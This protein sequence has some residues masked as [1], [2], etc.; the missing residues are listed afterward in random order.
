M[1]QQDQC[2]TSLPATMGEK[3]PQAFN[4]KYLGFREAKGLW[5]IKHTR[6]P[7]E[8]MVASVKQLKSVLN[9]MKLDIREDGC[10]LESIFKANIES[11]FFSIDSIS[12]GV[13]DVVYSRVFSMITVKQVTDFPSQ[14][15]FQCHAFICESKLTARKLTRALAVAF[16]HYSVVKVKCVPTTISSSLTASRLATIANG[17]RRFAVD[18]RTPEELQNDLKSQDSSE[19]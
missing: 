11:K 6:E 2:Q 19:A 14:S 17:Q 9:T 10:Q 15:P 4:V 12:Y 3:L 7:V 13:Q 8:T 16:H 5:G 1:L 18:L